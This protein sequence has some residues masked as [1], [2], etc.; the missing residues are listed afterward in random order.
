MLKYSNF[1][2]VASFFGLW[3]DSFFSHQLH[4]MGFFLIF[5]FGIF[6]G[7]ND[8]TLIENI[9][10]KDNAIKYSKVFFYYVAIVLAGAGLFYAIP[11][12]ALGLFILVSSYHFGEQQWI[13]QI[14]SASNTLKF[15]FQLSYGLLILFLIFALHAA[16]VGQIVYE[17]TSQPIQPSYFFIGLKI[18]AAILLFVGC[19]L[20]FK[21]REFK[22]LI[23]KELFYLIVLTIIFKASGL[24]W[25][26]ALYFVLWHSIPSMQDQIQFLYGRLNLKNFKKY[27]YKA[28][29]YWVISLLGMTIMYS[30]FKD[31]KIFNALFFSFLASIT[32]PHVLVIIKMFEKR[33]FGK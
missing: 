30:F 1:A 33:S 6:H 7:A 24:I 15:L 16:E 11:A 22:H 3:I 10:V 2:I 21:C 14:H 9:N 19:L 18:T 17:I 4:W 31:Q 26:F 12:L 32:F 20:Y 23:I 8:L 13:N 28:C 27:F 5:T 29:P 25:G